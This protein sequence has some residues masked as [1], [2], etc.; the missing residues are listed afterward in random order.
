[1]RQFD[2][3]LNKILEFAKKR[4]DIRIVI[5][6]GSRVNPNAPIDMFQD[7]D[8]LMI[9]NNPNYYNTN[10]EWIKT[11]GELVMIQ[12]N[13]I[14]IDKHIYLMLFKDLV[15]IDMTFFS[16]DKLSELEE[17]SLSF[18]LLDKDNIIK[19]L[20]NPSEVSYYV[21]R[22]SEKEFQKIIND[23]FWSLNNVVKGIYRDEIVYVKMMYEYVVKE[24]LITVLNWY[25][26]IKY[27]FQVNPG[28]FGKWFKRFLPKDLY[29][30]LLLTYSD[31]NYENIW[32]SLFYACELMRRVGTETAKYLGFTYPIQIDR[33]ML[34]YLQKVKRISK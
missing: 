15:R 18:V 22:P 21:K 5:L 3:V 16:L 33:N 34:E 14:N 6:N 1:M 13:Y 20:P 9:T 10:Q 12:H 32:N 19:A 25:I 17:D 24:N 30:L 29:D 23:F 4:D 8:V 2:T 26:G 7:Y 11:F 31:T 28:K 27:D